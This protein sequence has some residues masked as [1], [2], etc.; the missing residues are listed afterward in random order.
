MGGITMISAVIAASLLT[1]M[2]LKLERII[3]FVRII[4]VAL[5]CTFSLLAFFYYYP[6]FTEKLMQESEIKALLKLLLRT[7]MLYRIIGGGVGIA[8]AC[9]IQIK[10]PQVGNSISTF[11]L[12]A[13]ASALLLITSEATYT[14]SMILI[15]MIVVG[16]G[17]LS[18]RLWKRALFSI[19]TTAIV[20]GVIVA[21]LFTR[22]YFLPVWLFVTLAIIFSGIGILIQRS[23]WKKTLSK[24]EI[25]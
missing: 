9:L 12:F 15:I 7:D 20:G 10:F 1:C 22:F 3:G 25:Q 4:A 5:V 2:G 13:L 14:P 21:Q 23:A 8:V 11:L 6:T 24:E 17:A 19:W 16:L 18:L